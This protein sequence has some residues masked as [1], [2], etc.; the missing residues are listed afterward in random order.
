MLKKLISIVI[1]AY[2]EERNISHIYG[3]LLSVLTTLDTYSF[4]IIFVNDG[5]PDHTWR[6]IEQLCNTDER[7]KGVNLSRNFGKE[8]AITAG[9]EHARGDAIITIDADGQH[10]VERIPEFI[11]EWESGYDVVYNRRPAINGASWIKKTTSKIFYSAFNAISEFHLE[12]GTT[13]YRLVDRAVVDA[14]LRFSEK[15]RMYRGLVDWLGF[16][17]KVLV[18]DANS[19]LHGE[20]SYD[21]RMLIR[22]ALHSLTSFS[23]FPLK[24]VGYMGFLIVFF[25]FITLFFQFIDKIGITHY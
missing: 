20:A 21:Y 9:L 13:D 25:G 14:Y 17:R 23:S 10:P 3:E 8:L 1:P 16:S 18:F 11:Q 12:P 2:R 6:E 5:S 19:R 7:V 22:L 4:E 24:L 15:N